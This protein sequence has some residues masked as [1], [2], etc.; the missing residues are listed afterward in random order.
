MHF[1]ILLSSKLYLNFFNLPGKGV[2]TVGDSSSTLFEA[3][4]TFDFL[5]IITKYLH[6]MIYPWITDA[7]IMSTF[8]R[9][10]RGYRI[11]Y[12]RRYSIVQ[13]RVKS[14]VQVTVHLLL[15][16]S[17]FVSML[18]WSNRLWPVDSSS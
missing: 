15:T 1:N 2:Y 10:S 3:M 6:V 5:I 12:R 4:S 11:S 14:A 17:P 16:F 18:F 9:V 7:T 13:N 8:P